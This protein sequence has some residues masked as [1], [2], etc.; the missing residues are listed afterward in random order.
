RIDTAALDASRRRLDQL[1]RTRVQLAA[2]LVHEQRDRHT[3]NPLARDAPVGPIFDHAGDAL[4]SPCWSP[5]HFLDVAQRVL[6]QPLPI[7]ADEP[8]RSGAEDERAF[9]PP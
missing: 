6:P 2:A 5:L 1:L 8:L 3:P 9:V 4:L 7:H